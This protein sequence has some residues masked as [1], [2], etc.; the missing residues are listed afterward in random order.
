MKTKVFSLILAF[1]LAA[2]AAVPALAAEVTEAEVPVTL[3]IINAERKISVTVPAALPVSVVD[4]DVVTATNAAITNQAESG[5][6]RVTAV[7]V[8]PVSFAVG[9]YE[10]FS[11][12]VNSIAL[13]L[14]GCPTK[15]AGKLALTKD[16]FPAIEAGKSL[17]IQYD[18]KV[19]STEKVKG[20][21]AATVV[22]TIAAVENGGAQ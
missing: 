18:A 12:R 20:V 2:A 5:A 11:R 1:V 19:S 3:T 16:A 7:T 17:P 15:G 6:I 14:N 8:N 13:C 10:N 4:G 21:T 22:F 9:D